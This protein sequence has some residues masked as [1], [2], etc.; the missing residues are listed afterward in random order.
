MLYLLY[1]TNAG[2][3]KTGLSP[4]FQSLKTD[5]GTDKSGSAPTVTEIGG[6]WYKFTITFGTAPWDV[7]TAELVGVVDA[8]PSGSFGLPDSERYIPVSFTKRALGLAK[9]SHDGEQ[10]RATGVTT[11][12]SVDGASDEMDIALASLKLEFDSGGT[13][14]IAVGDTI[15]GATSEAT[16]VVAHV[17]LDSGTW[18]GGDADGKLFLSSVSGTFENNENLDVGVSTNLA[19]VDGTLVTSTNYKYTAAP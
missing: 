2:I 8:D 4:D 16:G 18:A 12:K 15:T 13:T 5:A 3:F 1:I 14:V 6:G 7:I 19:T 9:L 11:I 10:N 17:I